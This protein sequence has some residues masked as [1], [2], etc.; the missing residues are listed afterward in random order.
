MRKY[1]ALQPIMHNGRMHNPG[2]TIDC[3]S[4]DMAAAWL[5]SKAAKCIGSAS[6]SIP[7]AEHIEVA[8]IPN[9]PNTVDDPPK[10]EG[11]PPKTVDDPPEPPEGKP[12]KLGRSAPKS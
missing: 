5:R 4:P 8:V 12:V 10:I 11:D 6:Y 9:P 2:E 7:D 1:V 3:P